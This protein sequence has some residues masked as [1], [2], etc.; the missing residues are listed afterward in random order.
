MDNPESAVLSGTEHRANT[1]QIEPY[2]HW[3]L[4]P[5]S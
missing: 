3:R 1:F 4:Q 5:P 2:G